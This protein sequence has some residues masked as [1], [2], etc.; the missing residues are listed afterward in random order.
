MNTEEMLRRPHLTVRTNG[1]RLLPRVT[2]ES[3][4]T[5]PSL[6]P[7]PAQKRQILLARALDLAREDMQRRVPEESLRIVEFPLAHEKYAVEATFVQ[8]VY[9]IKQITPLPCTP[10]FVL[11]IVNVR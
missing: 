4:L 11:G 2:S 9:Q 3:T 10:P 7:T 6:V 8:E 1:G 5:E